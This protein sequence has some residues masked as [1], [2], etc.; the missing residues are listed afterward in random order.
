M[1]GIL[2]LFWFL[3]SFLPVM[4][5]LEKPTPTTDWHN[6]SPDEA[7][8]KKSLAHGWFKYPSGH[9]GR[10]FHYDCSF[11]PPPAEPLLIRP[12]ASLYLLT[13]VVGYYL[14]GNLFP[15]KW[16]PD[17]SLNQAE[18]VVFLVH[19]PGLVIQQLAN[20]SQRIDNSL[21]WEIRAQGWD[22]NPEP[23]FL[24]AVGPMDQGPARLRF[25][26]IKPLQAE[27]PAK[28]QSQNTCTSSTM[29][30]PK[31]EPLK[32]PNGSRDGASVNFMILKSS[33]VTNQILLPKINL[34]FGPDPMTTAKNQEN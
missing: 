15:I 1:K 20:S 2:F 18:S 23:I 7:H 3:A 31:E 17:K 13:Y 25:F 26:G 27:T 10:K 9:W 8:Q 14:L 12:N 5:A 30:A 19:Y 24:R 4:L 22:S 33:Q 34:G 28:S 11:T 21:P 29:V 16:V 32:L 6:S